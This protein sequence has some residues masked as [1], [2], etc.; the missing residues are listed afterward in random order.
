M[1]TKKEMK[2]DKFRYDYL[3]S[4][5]FGAHWKL[6]CLRL[7]EGSK[8]YEERSRLGDDEPIIRFIRKSANL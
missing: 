2:R 5:H 6:H 1:P 4:R 7:L 3:V 8:R